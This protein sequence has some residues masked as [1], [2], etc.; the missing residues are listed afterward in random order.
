MVPPPALPPDLLHAVPR[1]TSASTAAPRAYLRYIRNGSSPLPGV[2]IPRDVG[3]ADDTS[4]GNYGWGASGQARDRVR[5]V[6]RRSRMPSPTSV[7]TASDATRIEPAT[8]IPLSLCAKPSTMYRPRVP[9]PMSAESVAVA[10][11]VTA[12]VRT[13]A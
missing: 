8:S 10:T 5:G 2:P 7:M 4:D 11:T 3:A 9:P 1:S 6:R 13:P 12:E